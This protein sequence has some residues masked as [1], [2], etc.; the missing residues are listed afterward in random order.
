MD[1]TY[2]VLYSLGQKIFGELP[3]IYIAG[4]YGKKNGQI[5]R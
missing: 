4:F 2:L 1:E 3:L 5:Y